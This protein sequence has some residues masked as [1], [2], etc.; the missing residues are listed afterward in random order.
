MHITAFGGSVLNAYQQY[1]EVPASERHEL[2]FALKV[3]GSNSRDLGKSTVQEAPQHEG[4]SDQ[5]RMH[6]LRSEAFRSGY[7]E[8]V[9]KLFPEL[10]DAYLVF[11]T[12]KKGV[13][14]SGIQPA[15]QAAALNQVRENLASSIAAGKIPNLMAAETTHEA[16]QSAAS[17]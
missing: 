10:G 14:Q 8:D 16:Q 2:D 3:H 1:P 15:D 11:A 6:H 7:P 12:L 4:A 13:E 5:E 9:V 17:L